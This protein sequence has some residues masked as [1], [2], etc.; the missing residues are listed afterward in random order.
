MRAKLKQL[1]R[2]ASDP[3][4]QMPA[5]VTVGAL[6]WRWL[7]ALA[8]ID[9][10]LSFNDAR[11]AMAFQFMQTTGWWLL[12]LIGACWFWIEWSRRTDDA[13]ESPAP[14]FAAGSFVA[15]STVAFLFGALIAT[16][17]TGSVPNIVTGWGSALSGSCT[18]A[19]DTTRLQDFKSDYKIALA[20]GIE[21]A[22]A[23]KLEDQTIT[24]SNPF[25][26]IGGGQTIVAPYR[27][28]MTEHVKRL[29]DT[30]RAAAASAA[31]NHTPNNIAVQL[32]I[33]H[34]P[35]LVPNGVSIE[36][37]STLAELMRLGGKVLRPQYFR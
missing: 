21:D 29:T 24:F 3:A 20:C 15:Y 34:D 35:V 2:V 11:A 9:F 25:T 16:K 1:G 14:K 31:P 37:V 12:A 7:S 5:L 30:A 19:F 17:A 27:A 10:L 28:A 4:L 36:K 18:A 33:W 13:T 23:D 32:T 6:A 26:I 22:T 8:N